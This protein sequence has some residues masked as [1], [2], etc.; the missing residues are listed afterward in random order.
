MMP[1]APMLAVVNQMRIVAVL[2]N[3]PTLRKP[4]VFETNQLLVESRRLDGPTKRLIMPDA[5]ARAPTMPV[6]ADTPNTQ[7]VARIRP[8]MPKRKAY[9]QRRIASLFI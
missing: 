2:R 8:A 7:T 4:L 6:N 1:F 5:I 9:C 3:L